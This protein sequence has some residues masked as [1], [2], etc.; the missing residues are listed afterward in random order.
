V[1]SHAGG[2]VPIGRV[3]DAAVVGALL[4]A[5]LG[6]MVGVLLV[7]VDVPG[8]GVALGRT[9]AGDPPHAATVSSRASPA[10]DVRMGRL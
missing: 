4:G 5:L 9:D 6:A 8:S 2:T 7:L 3:V 10:T 1:P